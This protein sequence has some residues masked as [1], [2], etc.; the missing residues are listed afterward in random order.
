MSLCHEPWRLWQAA[1]TGPSPPPT[2][3]AAP[4]RP[5]PPTTTP[6]AGRAGPAAPP[7]TPTQAIEKPT[8]KMERRQGRGKKEGG[9]GWPLKWM[10]SKQHGAEL[11]GARESI[12]A[13]GL[14]VTAWTAPWRSVPR[15]QANAA[16]PLGRRQR[17]EGRLPVNALLQPAARVRRASPRLHVRPEPCPSA[18]PS[19]HAAPAALGRPR[20]SSE[21]DF[22]AKLHAAVYN[23]R[24]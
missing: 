8:E 10:S 9:E 12:M 16:R 5:E 2:T 19:M 15:V 20:P 22:G 4:T 1:G 3:A 7:R 11:G 17:R 23:M 24:K 13:G 6:G 21:R 18:R 14:A